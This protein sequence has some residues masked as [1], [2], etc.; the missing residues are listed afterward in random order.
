MSKSSVVFAIGLALTC[1]SAAQAQTQTLT[2]DELSPVDIPI[3][4]SVTC[5]TS[6][7]FRFSSDHF[8]LIGGTLTQTFTSNG[9][10]HIGYESGRGF[11]ILLERIGGGAF[12]LRSLDAAEFYSPEMPDRLDA[13]VLTITGFQAGGG[14]LIHSVVLDGVRDGVGGAPD[15]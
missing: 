10:S 5:G 15:F 1:A 12:A 9:T 4:G 3:L 8:H 2:F 11:P 13:E 6:T 7:G 14:I